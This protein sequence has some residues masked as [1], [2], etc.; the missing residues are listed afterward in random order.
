ML[1]FMQEKVRK[2][3]E[4]IN[5]KFKNEQLLVQSLTTPSLS[6]EI[7]VTSYE[8]LETLG[9]AVIKI[10][11]ILKLYRIGIT[12]SGEITK[13]KATLES[14]KALKNLAKKINLEKFIFTTESQR[15][16]G[17]RILADVFEAICGALFLDSNCDL[18][19]VE[20]I[21]IDPFYENLDNIIQDSIIS[22]KNVLLEFLQEKFKTNIIIKLE[23]QKS[24]KF[25]HEPIWVARNPRILEKDSEKELIKIPRN[26]KSDK[27][28]N[29]KDADKNLYAKILKHLKNKEK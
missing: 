8:F 19:L 15:V 26:L 9:D 12:D 21:I 29:K 17:T 14:D 24:G 20:Q 27:F 16:K 2:F 11:F 3:Q 22:S 13:I 23:Y 18:N 6:N 25:E 10:I 1:A 28:S 5:Y 4:F 7:G